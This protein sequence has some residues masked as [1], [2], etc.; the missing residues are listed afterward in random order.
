M[1]LDLIQQNLGNQEMDQIGC[2]LGTGPQQT[3]QAIAAALPLLLGALGR[4]SAEPKGAMA[5]SNAVDRDHDGSILDNLSGFLGEGNTGVGDGI[6]KHVLGD[7][8]TDVER[9]L[10]QASGLGGE[11]IS[12]LLSLLAPVVMGALGK[13]Q[14]NQGITT[15][16]LSTTLQQEAKSSA[17]ASPFDG[18]L[19]LLDSDGDGDVTDDITRLGSQLLGG[20]FN[21]R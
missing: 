20:F 1:I 16:N 17:A 13:A 3:Q 4:N 2:Q 12:K 15:G 9:G 18:L 7:R 6:L 14:R 11:S 8:R 10:Q 5:L 21:K 19:S